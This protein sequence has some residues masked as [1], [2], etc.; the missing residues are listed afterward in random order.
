MR[1]S[2]SC[3][4]IGSGAGEFCTVIGLR[5]PYELG[6]TNP[7]TG[8]YAFHDSI[9]AFKEERHALSFASTYSPPPGLRWALFN[10][11]TDWRRRIFERRICA[12]PDQVCLGALLDEVVPRDPDD[13][14][15]LLVWT[16]PDTKLA[17]ALCVEMR[18]STSELKRLTVFLRRPRRS[19]RTIVSR[20]SASRKAKELQSVI[21]NSSGIWMLVAADLARDMPLAP[22]GPALR[23]SLSVG[24]LRF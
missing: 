22:V 3:N 14:F 20:A 15:E 13:T 6:L 19:G 1:R 12:E 8:H 17:G 16:G 24:A 23:R 2:R 9:T 10:H 5:G 18:P 11:G 21:P 4:A 7:R